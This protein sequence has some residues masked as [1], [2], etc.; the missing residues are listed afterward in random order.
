MKLLLRLDRG[1]LTL[2]QAIDQHVFGHVR[3]DQCEPGVA[4]ADEDRETGECGEQALS[5]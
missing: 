5:D 2:Q 3:D 1:G 4:H